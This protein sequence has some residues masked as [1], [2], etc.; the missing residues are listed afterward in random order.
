MNTNE[1]IV[2]RVLCEEVQRL[3][4][5]AEYEQDRADRAEKELTEARKRIADLEF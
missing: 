4:W 1:N 2:I 5:K 3:T